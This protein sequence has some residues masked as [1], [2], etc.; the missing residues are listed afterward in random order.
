MPGS[1]RRHAK[2]VLARDRD[3]GHHVLRR[4][5]HRHGRRTLVDGEVPRPTRFVPAGVLG[6]NDSVSQA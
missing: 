6:P 5:R 2:A 4:L 3:H 1:L